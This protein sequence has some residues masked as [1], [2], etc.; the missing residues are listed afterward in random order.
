MHAIGAE[1]PDIVGLHR[2]DQRC[3]RRYPLAG[4][5]GDRDVEGNRGRHNDTIPGCV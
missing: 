2:H 5:P 4:L 1:A 3:C